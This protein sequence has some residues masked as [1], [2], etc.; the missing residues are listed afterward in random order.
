MSRWDAL[1][2]NRASWPLGPQKTAATASWPPSFPTRCS[3]SRRHRSGPSCHASRESSIAAGH[4]LALSALGALLALRVASLFTLELLLG[5]NSGH[6][7]V[8]VVF[9]LQL[10]HGGHR[11][12]AVTQPQLVGHLGQL[13]D[14]GQLRTGQVGD[15]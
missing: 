2:T 5:W 4:L 12:G 3:C 7:I 13:L 14:V 11:H 6:H 15:Q 10:L 9:R 1:S 8:A